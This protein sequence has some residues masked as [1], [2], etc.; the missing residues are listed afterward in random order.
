MRI[1]IVEDENTFLRN[2]TDVLRENG[3][4]VLPVY[5]R[6]TTKVSSKDCAA[7]TVSCSSIEEI[8]LAVNDFH[9]DKILIDHDLGAGGYMVGFQHV[10]NKSGENV[11]SALNINRENVIGTSHHF[12]QQYVSSVFAEKRTL[13]PY[14][15]AH[16]FGLSAEE[17]AEIQRQLVATVL[18]ERQGQVQRPEPPER[19]DI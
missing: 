3:F 12:D 2:M 1:V 11:I 15:P 5:A 4:E 6:L 9:P 7:G 16:S 17:H 13:G 14:D 18:G 10:L 8:I 19:L